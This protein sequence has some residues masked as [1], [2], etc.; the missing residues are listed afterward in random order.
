M[1]RTPVPPR[2]R[3][4]SIMDHDGDDAGP[5]PRGHVALDT[6]DDM[7]DSYDGL[8]AADIIDADER[9]FVMSLDDDVLGPDACRDASLMSTPSDDTVRSSMMS[10]A[11]PASYFQSRAPAMGD[12]SSKPTTHRPVFYSPDS[13]SRSPWTT[14]RSAVHRPLRSYTIESPH[15]SA[16]TRLLP[17]SPDPASGRGP[18]STPQCQGKNQRRPLLP[19]YPTTSAHIH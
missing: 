19:L 8:T 7:F 16:P 13:S 14:P 12:L 18:G 10:L 15:P 9:D 3:R 6:D 17:E 11:S 2:R 1:F 4:T 5:G